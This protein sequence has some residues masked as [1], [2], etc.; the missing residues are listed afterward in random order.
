M[1]KNNI[2]LYM[3][4]AAT[5]A[6][7][8]NVDSLD[9]PSANRGLSF[10]VAFEKEV[11]AK[12]GDIELRTKSGETS[13][14]LERVVN[15]KSVQIEDQGSFSTVYNGRFEVEGN[16]NGEAVFHA[17]A[18]FNSQTDLWDLEDPTYKWIPGQTLEV[19]ALAAENDFDNEAFFNGI[20]YNGPGS[21]KSTALIEYE[22]PAEP[23]QKDL[24]VGY[25]MGAVDPTGIV[26]LTFTHPLASIQFIVGN[27][28][29]GTQLT[30]NS[31]SLVGIDKQARCDV[32]FS[33]VV[34]SYVWK[35]HTGTTTYTKEF[36]N[37]QP[38]NPNDPILVGDNT[39]I[40]IPRDFPVESSGAKIVMNVTEGNKSYD[41]EASLDGQVWTPGET[42]VY[43]VSYR[44]VKKAIL[45]NGPD[46][47]NAM[48]TLA[49]RA[50]YI[51][52][53]VFEV[54][55]STQSETEVQEA[56]QWPIYLTWDSDTGTITV[57]TSDVAI[58]TGSSCRSM[59]AG[60]SEL[61][62]ITGLP[63]LDTKRATD[64]KQM[65]DGCQHLQRLELSNFNTAEVQDM[66]YMFRDFRVM[67]TL[68]VSSFN[69]EK[70]LNVEGMFKGYHQDSGTYV[71]ST[72]NNI[73]LGQNFKLPVATAFGYMF[74][75]TRVTKLDLRVMAAQKA[76]DLEY[77]FSRCPE[78][79]EVDMSTW[80]P[81]RDCTFARGM[82]V[83]CGKLE[84]IDFGA[85]M[86]LSHLPTNSR[87]NFFSNTPASGI[88]TNI[89]CNHNMGVWIKGLN[90]YSSSRHNVIEY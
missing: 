34:S 59:F 79:K 5:L 16:V 56:N 44:G 80:G 81:N 39:F 4:M 41:V 73:I 19:V 58:Y 24:L 26:K 6:I 31:I 77:M 20:T 10:N 55:S 68:D 15:T 3:G 76:G 64:M 38:L 83:N 25:Y 67:T 63:L 82:F 57:S 54:D 36:P 17:N 51:K 88:V 85:E 12:S 49:G 22:L 71:L 27:M 66:S 60:L 8:C 43:A 7:S 1:K 9:N 61:I 21:T 86:N 70:V 18:N 2:L 50:S 23:D 46:F 42:T 32:D 72:L 14:V 40:V 65:F 87:N 47:N 53:I 48:K 89:Y 90:T 62:D 28:P 84:K 52:H 33:N 29:S 69:T 11:G 75:Y 78:L 37:A 45:E 35:N 13:L 74:A 30:V